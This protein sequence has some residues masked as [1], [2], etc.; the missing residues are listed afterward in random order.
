MISDQRDGGARLWVQSAPDAEQALDFKPG[1]IGKRRQPRVDLEH[2]LTNLLDDAVTA[3]EELSQVVADL[4]L[5][6]A[7]SDW[8]PPISLLA[9]SDAPGKSPTATNACSALTGSRS[10]L[11][12]PRGT[13]DEVFRSATSAYG[14]GPG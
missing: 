1:R 6:E 13:F 12:R 11:I 9:R 3:A 7:D 5:A 14:G 10:Y 4:S 8:L 2:A